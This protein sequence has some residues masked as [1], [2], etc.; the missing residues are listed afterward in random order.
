MPS[1]R[2]LC[3]S[4]IKVC[5]CLHYLYSVPN[6][7]PGADGAEASSEEE[8]GMSGETGAGESSCVLVVVFSVL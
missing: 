6:E 7:G 5:C 4:D 2:P 8:P 1:T 3:G